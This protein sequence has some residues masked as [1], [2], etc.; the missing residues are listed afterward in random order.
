VT[1][2]SAHRVGRRWLLTQTGRGVVAV[3]VLSVAA[4]SDPGDSG[5]S[6]SEST[7]G[8]EEP[9][10]TPT[11][12]EPATASGEL[13]WSRVNLG[14]VSAYVLVRGREAAVVD[15]GVGGSLDAIVDV[16][17]EAGPGVSGVRHVV[18][19]HKHPDHAGSV[20]EVLAAATQATG[21]VG[22]AD[23]SE[24]DAPQRLT[25]LKDG[26]EVF[27]LQMIG[28]PGHTAGHVAVFDADT[29]VLVAGD[30]LTNMGGLTG[31]NPQFTEDEQAAA[32]SVQKLARLAPTTI[33]VGHGEP[34]VAGASAA[35]RELAGS[36]A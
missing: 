9:S 18:L 20:G 26:D 11:E 7:P 17:D 5:G 4:C 10:E 21:Y 22:E 13:A 15:T 36:L 1:A 8:S 32:A 24:V 25:P 2:W 3:A 30:A 14:F 12:S 27:G 19:T 34:V 6:A 33:L 16:L 28:T 29:G 31:S 35:L 23:L